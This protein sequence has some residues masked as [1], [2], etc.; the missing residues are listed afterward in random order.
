MTVQ[1]LIKN[2]F[3]LKKKQKEKT[4]KKNIVVH[5]NNLQENLV[6]ILNGKNYYNSIKSDKSVT[7]FA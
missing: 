1:Q 4:T 6:S 3:P 5:L 2:N 7:N